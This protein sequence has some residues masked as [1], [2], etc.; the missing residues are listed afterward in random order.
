MLFG[1]G[2]DCYDPTQ[3]PYRSHHRS[4][5]QHVG[6]LQGLKTIRLENRL[7]TRLQEVTNFRDCQ[8]E[9]TAHH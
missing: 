2:L 7:M 8:A 1:P 6:H 5:V 4:E 3:L 9:S